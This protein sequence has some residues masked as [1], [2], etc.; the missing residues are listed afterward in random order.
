M[1][2]PSTATAHL[3]LGFN[4]IDILIFI[5]TKF[6]SLQTCQL[7]VTALLRSIFSCLNLPAAVLVSLIET[8]REVENGTLAEWAK[9]LAQTRAVNHL[10]PVTPFLLIN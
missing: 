5:V 2:L 1:P 10:Y 8:L 6:H 7:S 3:S 4:I 9:D